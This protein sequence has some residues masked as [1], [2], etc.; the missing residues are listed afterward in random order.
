MKVIALINIKGGMGKTTMAVNLA[1][2]LANS[3]IIKR[4]D[5]GSNTPP[6]F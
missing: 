1:H 4:K 5:R 6:Q 3:P 2:C